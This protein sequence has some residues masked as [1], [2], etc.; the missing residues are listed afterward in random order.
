MKAIIKYLLLLLPL[1][2][3]AYTANAG[4]LPDSTDTEKRKWYAPDALTI[5]YAGNLGMFS[6]GVNYSFVH[7]KLNAEFLYGYVPRFDAEEALHLLSFKGIYKPFKKVELGNDYTLTPLRTNLAVSYHFRSQFSSSWD[8]SYPENYYWWISS[9]RITGGLG[10]AINKR[11]DVGNFK[12][13]SLYGEVGTYDLIVTSA[14][15][16]KTVTAWDIMSFG[17]GTSLSF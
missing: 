12:E 13:I 11:I 17:I 1:L 2:G 16:D 3:A 4:T 14:V 8:S 6:G 9:F 15:K 10:S 7:D 5:Q